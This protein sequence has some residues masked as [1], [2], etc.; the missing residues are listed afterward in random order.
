MCDLLPTG[1]SVPVLLAYLDPGTGSLVF[2]ILIAGVLSGLYY[3][4]SWSVAARRLLGRSPR[5]G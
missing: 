5:H 4:R 2:Q 1:A 3:V